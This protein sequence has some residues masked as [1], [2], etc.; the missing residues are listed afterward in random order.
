MTNRLE[1]YF[2]GNKGRAIYK[3]TSYF[4][5]YEKH[6]SQ[7][8]DRPVTI[9]EFGVMHGGSLQMWKNYFGERARIIGVDINPRCKELEED[10]IEIFIGDQADRKFLHKM[11]EAIGPI[12]VIIDDGGHIMK[13]QITTF[14]EMWPALKNG[15]VY[16]VEDTHTS[17]YPMFGGKL[18]KKNTFISLSKRLIDQMNAW[19]VDATAEPRLKIDEY[20][21]SVKAIHFYTS[22]VV[23]DKAEVTKPQADIRGQ[24]TDVE[25]N[26][27]GTYRR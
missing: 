22:I 25:F 6:F 10:Q 7:F 15:G 20:T 26:Y 9:L 4:E 23:F 5:S 18:G 2:Y 12:D 8:V 3:W 24:L 16:V 14:Q 21:E 27:P 1:D 13:Q 17:Y 19:F 11:K